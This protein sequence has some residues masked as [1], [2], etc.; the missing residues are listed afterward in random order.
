MRIIVFWALT[1]YDIANKKAISSEILDYTRVSLAPT[2]PIT[3]AAPKV[4]PTSLPAPDTVTDG[5]WEAEE[6]STEDHTEVVGPAEEATEERVVATVEEATLSE[7]EAAASDEEATEEEAEAVADEEATE[8]E[9][10]EI[11]ALEE[12]AASEEGA[13]LDDDDDEADEEADEEAEDEA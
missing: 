9:D 13:E 4:L 2:R 5:T 11:A 8:A 7:E 6:V 1:R 10:D 3:A 12:E